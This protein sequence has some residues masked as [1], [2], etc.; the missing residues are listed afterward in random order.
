MS[1][2]LLAASVGFANRQSA[3]C[4]LA[5]PAPRSAM[6]DYPLAM[7]LDSLAPGATLRGLV[8]QAAVTVVSVQWHGADAPALGQGGGC[9]HQGDG[10]SVVV[11]TLVLTSRRA[12]D[13]ESSASKRQNPVPTARWVTAP[14]LA[15]EVVAKD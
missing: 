10:G 8:P 15:R 5:S 7:N 6:H 4:A 14:A 12:E 13:A 11:A 3:E 1:H 9:R 2:A